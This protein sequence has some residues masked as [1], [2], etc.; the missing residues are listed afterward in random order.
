MKI[1]KWAGVRSDYVNAFLQKL[2][3]HISFEVSECHEGDPLPGFLCCYDLHPHFHGTTYL[4]ISFL[5]A[6]FTIQA[7]PS[8]LFFIIY[9]LLN[10]EARALIKSLSCLQTYRAS[11][12]IYRLKSSSLNMEAIETPIHFS[13]GISIFPLPN[14]CYYQRGQIFVHIPS[15]CSLIIAWFGQAQVKL[16]SHIS[17]FALSCPGRYKAAIN[18]S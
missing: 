8:S 15:L 14:L 11:L 16:P 12:K 2:C 13:N 7:M 10:I 1:K 9:T 4:S 17:G 3:L 5:L 6:R 18:A